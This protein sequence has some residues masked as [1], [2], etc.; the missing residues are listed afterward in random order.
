[1]GNTKQV[2]LDYHSVNI[3]TLPD[4]NGDGVATEQE[5]FDEIRLNWPTYAN[6][7]VNVV[8]EPLQPDIISN[9][10]WSYYE[11]DFNDYWNTDDGLKTIIE[12]DTDISGWN[13]IT[14]DATVICSSF[15]NNCCWVFS[16][17]WASQIGNSNNGSHPVSGNRQFG[18]KQLNN[19]SY[20]F[21]IRGAD[22]ARINWAVKSM[23]WLT[24]NNSTEIFYEITDQAWNNL[25]SNIVS[26]INDPNN[27]GV[28]SQNP[29]TIL[30]PDWNEIKD[31]LKSDQP[32][33]IPCKY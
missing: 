3:L 31:K 26:L 8:L 27:G 16:T 33:T 13:P 6:G 21:Y 22:R 12:I 24:G 14:D 2:N 7:Q 5:L 20:E 4:I 19:G 28:A 15:E 32:L 10:T 30:R 23:S 29:P 1:M 17:V 25:T 9:N 11:N 18:I